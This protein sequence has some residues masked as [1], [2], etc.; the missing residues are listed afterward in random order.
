MNA[1]AAGKGGWLA[2][3][4]N[5]ETFL[6]LLRASADGRSRTQQTVSGLDEPAD[7][8]SVTSAPA[9]LLA[10]GYVCQGPDPGSGPFAPAIWASADG[11]K[12]DRLTIE[13][14]SGFLTGIVAVDGRLWVLRAVQRE[15]LVC[16]CDL[17]AGRW[18]AARE[19]A[20]TNQFILGLVPW[21]QRI[22]SSTRFP[23]ETSL[24][25][26]NRATKSF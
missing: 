8:L 16:G 22:R 13:G 9:G 18:L 6:P 19:L 24:P 25:S 11:R 26:T 7:I 17:W 20:V 14:S 23:P 2:I 3:A 5:Y 15:E 21:S 10:A 4:S 12:W 1:I